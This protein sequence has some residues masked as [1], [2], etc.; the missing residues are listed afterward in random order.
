MSAP[1]GY[2]TSSNLYAVM[3]CSLTPV[4]QVMDEPLFADFPNQHLQVPFRLRRET[5][6]PFH[7]CGR[8]VTQRQVEASEQVSDRQI[9]L[10]IGETAQ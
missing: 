10:C 9:E 5:I 6:I 4:E 1:S 3:G 8:R 7:R 2:Q